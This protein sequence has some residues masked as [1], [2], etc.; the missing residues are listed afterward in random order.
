M[1]RSMYTAVS[2][3]RTHQ[4]KM[5]TIGHNIANVNTVGYK[6]S[7]VTFK[8]AFSQM[9]S[10][11]SGPQG[12]KGGTN[13]QQIGLGVGTGGI[14]VVHT[15]GN[16]QRTEKPTDL[17][18]NGEG[19]FTVSDDPGFANRFYTRDGSFGV[20]TAG[21]L[22]SSE[23]YKVLGYRFDKDGKRT[24]E[25]GNIVINKSETIAPTSTKGITFKG[26]LNANS[27][28][29]KETMTTFVYDSLGNQY[30]LSFEA[31][32]KTTDPDTKDASWNLELTRIKDVKTGNYKDITGDNL[33]KIEL[34]KEIASLKAKKTSL[35]NEKGIQVPI[36]NNSKV[37]KQNDLTQKETEITNQQTVVGQKQTKYDTDKAAYD[38][39]K[40]EDADYDDKKTAYDTAKADLETE[41]AEL[42]KLEK[43]KAD[44]QKEI[45]DID[46]K[47][48]S[49]DDDIKKTADRIDKLEDDL[50]KLGDTVDTFKTSFKF[51]SK[52][53]LIGV[54]GDE[55]K[56]LDLDGNML[57]NIK[58]NKDKED[59]Y[60]EEGMVIPG[61]FEDKISVIKTDNADSYSNITQYANE[62]TLKPF[63]NDGNSS[64]TLDGFTI[65]P[66][67]II[68][69]KFT[70][71]EQRPLGQV[72]LTK[73]DNPMGL[74]KLG[75]NV[76]T[77]TR[78]SGEPQ[79]GVA[80]TRGFGSIQ[81]GSLEMSNVDISFEF[82]EMITTQRGFQANSRVITTS[83]EM[84]QELV[85]I[86]R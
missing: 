36:L 56:D 82:T 75:G 63:K 17:M 55:I 24:D 46:K 4:G 27:K 25:P 32:D 9:M 16:T 86:K 48:K 61:N 71:G 19:F 30:E 53:N 23:G 39:A 28:E 3:L 51:N 6:K 60:L 1:M 38:A 47:I 50:S 81:G 8:E 68:M 18:I 14:A 26:N 70:N 83:D 77:E 80:N 64:G 73:F 11:A 74:E 58:L 10:G 34:P 5:D 42:K 15:Q 52:G 37:A 33:K 62:T 76:F 21:N 78:N 40:P 12:G 13:P 59:Q 41:Q 2:G 54:D 65:D 29:S 67:G 45:D 7:Q 22:V 49:Y 20:D 44:I 72:M 69:G 79:N 57:K 35:E 43:E 84:L 31:K 66:S 85:N